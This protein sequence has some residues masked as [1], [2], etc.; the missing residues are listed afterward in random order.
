MKTRMVWPKDGTDGIAFI[1]RHSDGYGYIVEARATTGRFNGRVVGYVSR[2]EAGFRGRQW[3]SEI[4][5]RQH[6]TLRD[7]AQCAI[8][9]ARAQ[10]EKRAMDAHIRSI[11]AVSERTGLGVEHVLRLI[12][13]NVPVA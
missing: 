7:A 2:N 8:V 5:N 4:D 9:A 10:A 12:G 13:P 6:E 1:D 11:L 3:E